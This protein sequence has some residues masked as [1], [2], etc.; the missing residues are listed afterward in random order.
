ML[1]IRLLKR[2]L[3]TLPQKKLSELRGASVVN[4][5]NSAVAIV[6][7]LNQ[8][9][10]LL[11]MTAAERSLKQQI[12]T[13]KHEMTDIRQQLSQSDITVFKDFSE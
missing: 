13:L 11:S 7:Y 10:E 9:V 6:A 1:L 5:G 4:F 2:Q 3:F 12:D 8:Q